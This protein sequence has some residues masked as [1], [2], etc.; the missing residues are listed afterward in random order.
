M[1]LT[2]SRSQTIPPTGGPARP[3]GPADGA[4]GPCSTLH[5]GLANY[6]RCMTWDEDERQKR[7]EGM[8][9]AKDI[10]E[11]ERLHQAAVRDEARE[12]ARNDLRAA[13][14]LADQ[15]LNELAALGFTRD[16]ISLL[17]LVPVVQV[18]WADGTV[19]DAER[20]RLLELART[21]NIADGSAADSQLRQ[22]LSH[23]PEEKVFASAGHLIAAM[24]SGPQ[25]GNLSADDVVKYC[26]IIA[27]ASGGV[28]GVHRISAE[29]RA[30]ITSI[31]SELKSQK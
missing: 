12:E 23:R 16:T 6:D 9:L 17:P 19:S 15:Q 24:L 7:V 28:L 27:S 29:E 14:G 5:G 4:F 11:S 20:T 18:A 21:R 1:S 26:E 30:L 3:N 31:A 22:W 8:F 13:T 10:E 2:P 25:A